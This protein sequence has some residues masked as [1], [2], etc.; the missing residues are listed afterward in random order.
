MDI[1]VEFLLIV[2]VVGLLDR[3]SQADS[4]SRMRSPVVP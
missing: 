3:C 2:V 1:L 4:L